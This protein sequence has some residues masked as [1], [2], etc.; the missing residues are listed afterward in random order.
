MGSR[1]IEPQLSRFIRECVEGVEQLR[2]PMRRNWFTLVFLG[3]F[4]CGWSVPGI[5]AIDQVSQNFD[6]FLIFWL[7]GWA[8]CLTFAAATICSQIAGSEIIRVVGRDLETSVGVGGLRWRRLYRGDHIRNLR[9]S[10]PNPPGWLFRWQ[11]TN[12]FRPRAGALKFDYGSE[13]IFAASSSEEAEGRMIVDWLR[14]K[15]PTSATDQS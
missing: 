4:I 9:S 10:D 7:G 12:P 15:L 2:I 14:P 3:F 6:W 11:Q 13:T 1:Y 8:L 5:V